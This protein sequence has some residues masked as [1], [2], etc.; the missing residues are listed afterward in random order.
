MF[1]KFIKFLISV[2]RKAC[3]KYK[4]WWDHSKILK[5]RST[6]YQKKL[7]CKWWSSFNRRLKYGFI[8]R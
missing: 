1:V 2:C 5:W 6:E 4:Q 3:G 8:I 7:T